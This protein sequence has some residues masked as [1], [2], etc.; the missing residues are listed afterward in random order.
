MDGVLINS[1]PLHHQSERELLGRYGV[2]ITDEELQ[3]YAGKDATQLLNE[4]IQHYNLPVSFKDFYPEHKTNLERVFRESTLETCGAETLIQQLKDGQVPMALAS[5]SHR[6]LIDLILNKLD[7][8]DTFQIIVGGDEIKRGKPFPD[9][10]LKAASF[11]ECDPKT[12]AAIE[13]SFNGVQSAKDAGL[14]CIGFQNPTSG[15]QNLSRADMIIHQFSELP[16]QELFS[17]KTV[18]QTSG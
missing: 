16:V 18:I 2:S 5:S 8:K 11:L 6:S 15:N 10:Y 13:D 3:S 14:F 9:I 7:L 1:E 12:C 17:I 4:F